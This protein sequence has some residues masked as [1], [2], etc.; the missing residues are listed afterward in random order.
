[1]TGFALARTGICRKSR[2]L[3]VKEA[4][5]M[6]KAQAL[7][8]LARQIKPAAARVKP[9]GDSSL[10]VDLKSGQRVIIYLLHQQTDLSLSLL[11]RSMRS[12][13]RDEVHTLFVLNAELLP[14][15]GEWFPVS[16]DEP[17]QEQE[18]LRLLYELYWGKVYAYRVL[19][20]GGDSVLTV[21]PVYKADGR[22]VHGDPVEVD[23]IECDDVFVEAYRFKGVFHVA[24]FGGRGG[25][26]SYAAAF[27][28]DPMQPFFET[29][30]LSCNADLD[31]IKTAYRRLARKYHPDADPS[32]DATE[33]MQLINEAY[34]QIMT[35]FKG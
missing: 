21:L 31:E 24:N 15:Q 9:F 6:S 25:F 4:V 16:F 30:G 34:T 26:S 8:G 2:S 5:L 33:R 7:E 32:P 27:E 11:K 18:A 35:R 19:G 3:V 23:L 14:G 10:L 29:L 13:T 12:N 20:S 1:M 28:M 17:S 22:A